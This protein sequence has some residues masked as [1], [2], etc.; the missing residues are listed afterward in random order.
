VPPDSHPLADSGPLTPLV[1]GT[2]A[3]ERLRRPVLAGGEPI[4]GTGVLGMPSRTDWCL[5]WPGGSPEQARR[6]AWRT[7]VLLHG[8]HAVPG[9]GT[10]AGGALELYHGE[11]K[12]VRVKREKKKEHSSS[13]ARSR[14]S[15][16]GG[17]SGPA[18]SAPLPRR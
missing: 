15:A 11:A 8:G 1:S 4:G 10:V 17:G 9:H 18:K 7:A 6:R 14:A 12:P 2:E 13:P 16:S 3:G 5:A